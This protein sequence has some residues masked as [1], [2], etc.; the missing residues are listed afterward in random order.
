MFMEECFTL[1]TLLINGMQRGFDALQHFYPFIDTCISL[2]MKNNIQRWFFRDEEIPLFECIFVAGLYYDQTRDKL[3][4]Y[5][6]EQLPA[7][8]NYVSFSW[9]LRISRLASSKVCNYLT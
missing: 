5:I 2:Q 1:Q 4:P 8:V 9:G 3:V 6:K 7:E